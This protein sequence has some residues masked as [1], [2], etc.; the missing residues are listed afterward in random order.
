MIFKNCIILSDLFELYHLEEAMFMDIT[1]SLPNRMELDNRK[2][3]LTIIDN[4]QIRWNSIYFAVQLALFCDVRLRNSIP[5]DLTKRKIFLVRIFLLITTKMN[6]LFSRASYLFFID[7]QY[8][9]KEIAKQKRMALFES[10]SYALISS[11]STRR[12]RKLNTYG[13]KNRDF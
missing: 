13:N 8:G 2:C 12:K 10:Y 5:L 6:L 4:N 3:H 7:C 9:C 11:K 1:E